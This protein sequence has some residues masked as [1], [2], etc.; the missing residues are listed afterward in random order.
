M[1]LSKEVERG[2]STVK[3]ETGR[4]DLDYAFHSASKIVTM[5]EDREVKHE[6]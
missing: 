1:G 6:E 3:T 5:N 4:G 2:S